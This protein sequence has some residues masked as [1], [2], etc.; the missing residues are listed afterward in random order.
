M[1]SKS[2]ELDCLPTHILKDYIDSFIPILTKIVNLSLDRGV[3]S[4]DWKTAIL[5]PLLKKSG[6]DPIDSN[7]RPISNLSFISK[8]VEWAL[9]NQFN[10]HC[11]LNGI[12]PIHQSAY[13]Q[14]HSCKTAMIKIVNDTLWAME[15]KNITIL[16]IIDLNVALDTVDH[17]VLLEVLHKCFGV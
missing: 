15:Q 8:L 13:K 12:T 16:V 11:D 2:C 17:K 4:E 7:Y 14:L 9:I 10:T 6:L 5:R 3:F 1:Q